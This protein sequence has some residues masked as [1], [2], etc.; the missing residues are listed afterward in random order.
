VD[1]LQYWIIALVVS[2]TFQIVGVFASVYGAEEYF[3]KVFPAPENP[4]FGQLVMAA[5]WRIWIPADVETLRGVVVHQHGC[6][7][8]SGDGGRTAVYDLHWQELARKHDCALMAVSYR[9]EDFAC[10]AWCDPRNGSAQSFFDALEYFAGLT[11][12]EELARIPW[13]LWGH[14]G[15]AHWVG[16]MCQLY[17]KRIVG[18][19]LRSGCPD[20][21]GFTFKELPMNEDVIN[22]PMMLN[23]GAHEHDF[24]IVWNTCW[25]YFSVMRQ[26]DA[27]IGMIVDPKTSHETGNSR[28]PAIRFLDDCLDARLPAEAGSSE[29]RASPVGYVLPIDD[30]MDAEISAENIVI[31]PEKPNGNYSATERREFLKDGLWFLNKEYVD[32]W[33]KYSIDCSFEDFTPPPAPSNVTVTSDGL[34]SWNC[35]ADLESGLKTFVVYCDGKIIQELEGAPVCNARPAFQGI[36]YSDTPDYSLPEMKFLIE[37]YDP[38]R[39]YSVAAVNTCDLVSEPVNAENVD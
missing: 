20:T 14:S 35:R 21:V 6:G 17:P 9:Q 22:V 2:F 16:S 36:M 10:E 25:P 13:A 24:N 34:I 1:K 26:N 30:V 19:W 18:A 32:V 15:G 4:A 11:G 5:E 28:Y 3:E 33:R 27:K 39:Q 7:S 12:H 38:S 29:L 31:D 8:G 37:E 23:L